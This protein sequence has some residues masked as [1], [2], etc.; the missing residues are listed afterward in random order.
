MQLKNHIHETIATEVFTQIGASVNIKERVKPETK[1]VQIPMMLKRYWTSKNRVK[2]NYSSKHSYWWRCVEKVLKMS[3]RRLQRNIFSSSKMSSRRVCK[4]SS[5]RCLEEVVF[6]SS[7]NEISK[8][9]SREIRRCS[10]HD[11]IKLQ[12]DILKNDILPLTEKT[13]Q[14]LKQKY[15]P[16]CNAGPDV[17]LPDKPEEAHPIKFASIDVESV[18]KATLKT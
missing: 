14:Q 17:L 12:T 18:R 1:L 9:F 3:W 10:I 4:T 11:A 6:E 15:P 2:I 7:A 8:K 13:L 16:R 5:C